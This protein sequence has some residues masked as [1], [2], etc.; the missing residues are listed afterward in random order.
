MRKPRR[1]PRFFENFCNLKVSFSVYISERSFKKKEVAILDDEKIVDLYWDRSEDA[2]HQ[3]QEKYGK[4][5]HSIAYNILRSKEDSEECVNDAYK[6]LWD[7]IPPKKPSSLGGYIA[8]ITRNIA[9][10]RYDYNTAKKRD[11]NASIIYEEFENCLPAA[12]DGMPLSDSIALKTAINGFLSSLM[13]QD[14]IIF[15]QRY[16]YFCDIKTIARNLEVTESYVKI[17]LFRIRSKMKLYLEKEG[18]NI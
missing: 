3:T 4:Y 12:Q 18:I 16:W 2:I 14:R 15:M 6:K 17:T 9:L 10:D 11:Q 1:L 5:C 8:K 7:T 13:S